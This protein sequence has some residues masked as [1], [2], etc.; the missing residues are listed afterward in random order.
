MIQG[1]GYT[2]IPRAKLSPGVVA[3]LSLP[4]AEPAPY[5]V[6]TQPPVPPPARLV[7]V[8]QPATSGAPTAPPVTVLAPTTYPG[9]PSSLAQS[10]DPS[11]RCGD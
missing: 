1:P 10:A 7:V 11:R 5:Q 8:H 4:L 9:P 6:I 2:P 3:V